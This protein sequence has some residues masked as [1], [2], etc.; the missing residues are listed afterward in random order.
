MPSRLD[1]QTGHRFGRY[2]VLREVQRRHGSRRFLCRCDCGAEKAVDLRSLRRGD[3]VSCGCYSRQLVRQRNTKHGLH[4]TR[5][6]RTWVGIKS[7]CLNPK[8]GAYRRY[9]GRGITIC[10]EWMAFE[11]FR[12]WAMAHGYR[13]DLT[14]ERKDNDGPYAPENC[15]WIS[16]ADQARNTRKAQ[17]VWLNGRGM[18]LRQWA[19]TA[20]IPWAT[21]QARLKV[22]MSLE[23]ALIA[24]A[25][26]GRRWPEV[27][28]R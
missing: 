13:D 12:E 9:G 6:Y 25:H 24:P 27:S 3:A 14:I 28:P 2:T 15:T 23:E 8:N 19:Q 4:A 22:G 26:R 21:F 7:R 10:A 17:R 11:P 5:L 18:T 1:V 16:H 20:G